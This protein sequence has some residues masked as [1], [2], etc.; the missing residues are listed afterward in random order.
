[1]LIRIK[2][3]GK[4]R[5]LSEK[6]TTVSDL[7]AKINELFGIPASHLQIVYKDCDG[8]LVDVVDDEDLKN[9]YN[10]VNELN[11]TSLTFIIKNRKMTSRSLSR[12]N[13]SKNSGEES[14][15]SMS[16][17]LPATRGIVSIEISKPTEAPI[18]ENS[19]SNKGDLNILGS[20]N[21]SQ[22]QKQI[23][24]SNR[25]E[26]NPIT[27]MQEV[28]QAVG[29][30]CPGLNS[31]SVLLSAVL[32]SCAQDL[33]TLLKR[34]YKDVVKRQ[35]EILTLT[36]SNEEGWNKGDLASRREAKTEIADSLMNQKE[37]TAGGKQSVTVEK[38]TNSRGG[39]F[40]F[41]GKDRNYPQ[42]YGNRH[43]SYQSYHQTSA[44]SRDRAQLP[45]YNQHYTARDTRRYPTNDYDRHAD[46]SAIAEPLRKLC[47]KFPQKSRM[48]LRTILLQNPDKSVHQLE[49]LITQSRKSKSKYY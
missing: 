12:E 39:N 6:V 47:Q 28:L 31:N 45:A 13:R 5:K 36:Q 41:R 10:E 38:P 48:E 27:F 15:G 32:G 4:S 34:H 2:F 7:K 9:C 18:S 8:E 33:E 22:D 14:K 25:V 43:N 49:S 17:F 35:P 16:H 26:T 21:I 30:E 46:D 37:G 42:S 23:E 40:E 11:Q 44:P 24:S 19:F 20:L 1:M 29:D 3:D